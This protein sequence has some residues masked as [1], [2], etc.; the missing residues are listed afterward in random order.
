MAAEKALELL[1][2]LAITVKPTDTAVLKKIAGTAITG[3]NAE[4]AKDAL[5]NII[6][7]AIVFVTDADGT[8]DIS[9]INVEKKTGGSIDDTELIEGMVID[10][11]RAHPNMRSR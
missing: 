6:V 11:E 4:V 7:K 3:K 2:D 9:H 5:C 10:K 1:D 8:A